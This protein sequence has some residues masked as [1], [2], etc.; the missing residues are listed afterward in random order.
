MCKTVLHTLHIRYTVSRAFN[1]VKIAWV[2]GLGATLPAA[3]P[4][5]LVE[6][7]LPG[8]RPGLVRV[9]GVSLRRNAA[10]PYD[11]NLWFRL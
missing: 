4:I 3:L 10:L 2:A 5:E 1:C 11:N 8:S 9:E 7:A 6:G